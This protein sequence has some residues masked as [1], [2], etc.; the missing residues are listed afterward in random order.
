MAT[1]DVSH[2][3]ALTCIDGTQLLQDGPHLLQALYRFNYF[4]RHFVTH[5]YPII[6][7]MLRGFYGIPVGAPV[8]LCLQGKTW[9]ALSL[10]SLH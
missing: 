9:L 7:R 6:V 2:T 5:R 10:L 3:N 8:H 1:L 4:H